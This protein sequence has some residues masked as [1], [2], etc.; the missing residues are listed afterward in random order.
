MYNTLVPHYIRQYLNIRFSNDINTSCVCCN[1]VGKIKLLSTSIVFYVVLLVLPWKISLN[2]F[3]FLAPLPCRDY[4]LLVWPESNSNVM[5]LRTIFETP[6]VRVTFSWHLW[7][8]CCG[9]LRF[10]R[11]TCRIESTYFSGL[12]RLTF[13]CVDCIR[14]CV[15]CEP[16]RDEKACH[17]QARRMPSGTVPTYSRHHSVST[18]KARSYGDCEQVSCSGG[19]CDAHQNKDNHHNH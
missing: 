15:L 3:Y 11:S 14:G 9:I 6:H 5:I 2:A 19:N 16:R 4:Q 7:F 17:R 8:V 12:Y 13:V 18:K 1:Q 10:L